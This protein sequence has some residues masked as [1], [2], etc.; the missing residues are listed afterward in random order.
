MAFSSA[1]VLSGTPTAT[2]SGSITFTA[3]NA[4]G[5]DSRALTLTVNAA[6]SFATP[7]NILTPTIETVISGATINQVGTMLRVKR[8]G[9]PATQ[10][11]T[12]DWGD[13]AAEYPNPGIR[14]GYLGATVKFALSRR[15]QWLR[16]GVAIPEQNGIVYTLTSDD[17]GATI[18]VQESVARIV[19][20]STNTNFQESTTATASIN[21]TQT[22]TSISG[23]QTSTLVYKN[24]LSYLGSFRLHNAYFDV[25]SIANIDVV[26]AVAF[27]AD[28]ASGNGSFYIYNQNGYTTE[29]SIPATLS[30]GWST[31]L[32]SLPEAAILQNPRNVT[33]GWTTTGN[34]GIAIHG[35]LIYN[36]N[37]IQ[38]GGNIYSF[39][40]PNL[41]HAKRSKTL[42]TVGIIGT[43]LV[44]PSGGYGNGRFLSGPMCLIP[45]SWQTAL[46][47]KAL[48][49]WAGISVNSNANK[50]APAYAF[51]PD[52][53]GTGNVTA[54]TLL[55]YSNAQPLDS[56][57]QTVSPV[58]DI[59]GSQAPLWSATS[60]G[61]GVY[62]M[63]IPYGTDSLLYF[64]VNP[65]GLQ[66]YTNTNDYGV[67]GINSYYGGGTRN[68]FDPYNQ[69]GNTPYSGT[70]SVQCWAYNLNDLAAVKAGSV[71]PYNV[72]PYAAWSLSLPYS[73][74]SAN[75]S[76]LTTSAQSC[77]CA[78]I[79]DSIRK[80][81]YIFHQP[82][83]TYEPCISVFSVSN[84]V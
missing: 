66:G 47:G 75:N 13:P 63:S 58:V 3:A 28:G 61:Y 65:V 83:G 4:Y 24:N 57:S 35:Q 67:D 60:F 20:N 49:G 16:N 64:G 68:G 56:E 18:S 10:S 45:S 33:D 9:W 6:G 73:T 82:S 54:Q 34:D 11:W 48:T 84:A 55:F 32:G 38:D 78:S 5:S 14:P 40:T 1:G 80:R 53:V 74:I 36:G 19:P 29:Y 27:D 70:Y 26:R 25:P 30:N 46:G 72:R 2:A 43:S 44:S 15:Y 79:Y 17:V 69:S 50:G 42:S 51:D 71:L 23:T 81:I 39:V 76:S 52:L 41:T 8:G 59:H 37:L 31:S 62:G 12:L 77:V 21:S 22:I 7:S